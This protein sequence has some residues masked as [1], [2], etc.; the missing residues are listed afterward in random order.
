ME[1]SA[2]TPR[3]NAEKGVAAKAQNAS[4]VSRSPGEG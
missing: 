1:R 2:R 4:A 3:K